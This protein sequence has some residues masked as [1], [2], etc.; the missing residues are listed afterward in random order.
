MARAEV[1][2]SQFDDV[3]QQR[4]AATLGMWM[5]LATEMLFFGA[6]LL[7]YLIGRFTHAAHSR[8]RRPPRDPSR[9]RE[10]GGAA[11]E[12]PRDGLCR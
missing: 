6:P 4:A 9:R 12:Q 10:H 7:V 1:L 2:E 5:F 8:P 3:A 11:H